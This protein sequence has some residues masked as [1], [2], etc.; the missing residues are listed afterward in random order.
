MRTRGWPLLLSS[1]LPS[2]SISRASCFLA[3]AAALDPPQGRSHILAV[4]GSTKRRE[5]HR[6]LDAGVAALLMNRR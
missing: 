3:A 1:P 2:P 4:T 5:G 6:L